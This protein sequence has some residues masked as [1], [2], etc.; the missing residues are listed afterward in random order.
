MIK[1]GIGGQIGAGK[2]EVAK[3]LQEFFIADGYPTVIIK[4]DEVAWGLY[5]PGSPVYKRILKAFGENIL[6]SQNQIDRKKLAQIVFSHRKH[7]N[8]LNQIVHPP[9]IKE[10]CVKLKNSPQEIKI[11]DAALLFMWGNKVP[12]D[13]RILVRAPNCQ[14]IIRMKKKGFQPNEIKKRLSFQMDED[15]METLADFVIIND[16][17]YKVLHERTYKL[18]Q[19]IKAYFKEK[20][21]L[22]S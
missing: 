6:D 22:S 2:S 13:L 19:I 9:L 17:S 11:L 5:F 15:K 18:Y 7:L 21:Q 10:I 20:L 14:K 12:L 1:L 16:S 4:A 8:F 3:M